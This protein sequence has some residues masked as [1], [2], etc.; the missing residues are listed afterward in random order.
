MGARSGLCYDAGMLNLGTPHRCFRR[1]LATGLLLVW[2][3]P[4]LAQA[5]MADVLSGELVNPEVGAFAWYRVVDADTRA[6][7]FMRQA[8][9]GKKR[10][11]RKKGWWLETQVVP[12]AGAPTVYKMLLTGPASDAANIHEIVIQRGADPPEYVKAADVPSTTP[13]ATDLP[14][15]SLGM[16]KV[17]TVVGEVEAEHFVVGEPD[18]PAMDIWINAQIPPMGIVRIQSPE[19]EMLI[20]RHGKGGKDGESVLAPQKKRR[21]RLFR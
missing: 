10:V 11:G 20:Q 9:V 4:A 21:W 6:L 19:G 15:T 13:V 17:P 7:S 1:A 3:V 12:A 8:I 5:P 14:R 2:G 16:E 18:H